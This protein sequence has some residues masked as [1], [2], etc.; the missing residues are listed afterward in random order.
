MLACLTFIFSSLLELAIVGYLSEKVNNRK[1]SSDAGSNNNNVTASTTA[2]SNS[3]SESD[4]RR[5]SSP[6]GTGGDNAST[7][8]TSSSTYSLHYPHC[9]HQRRSSSASSF[10]R[11]PMPYNSKACICG[12]IGQ[13]TRPSRSSVPEEK[14]KLLPGSAHSYLIL[15]SYLQDRH[16]LEQ[17]LTTCASKLRRYFSLSSW[18][19]DVIDVISSVIFPT[20]FSLFNICYWGHYLR[21]MTW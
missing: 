21:I 8:K 15:E 4:F 20:L 18:S 19:A 11:V 10:D 12:G 1:P 6:P 3:L 2:A 5:F 9:S 17:Q 7:P 16:T 13:K 14:G